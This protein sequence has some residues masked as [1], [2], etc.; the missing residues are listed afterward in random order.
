MSRTPSPPAS[1]PDAP[2][3]PVV[4]IL[5]FDADGDDRAIDIEEFQLDTLGER[6]LAWIDLRAGDE[7][8]LE[9]VMQRL[10]LQD[11]PMWALL[12]PGRPPLNTQ[13]DWFCARAMAPR[14]DEDSGAYHGDAWLLAVGP[15]TV[16]TAHRAPLTFLDELF[17]HE[18]PASQVGVMEADSFAASLLDRML[19]VYLDQLH[20]FEDRLD[21]LEVKILQP[22]IRESYLPQLRRMRRTVSTLR[23]LLASHRDLFD[24]LSRADFRPELDEPMRLQFRGIS[25]RYER[26]VDAVENARDLVIGSFELY[27]T[28]LSQRTNQSMHALTFFTV[29]LGSLAVIA[30]ALGMNFRAPLFESGATGFWTTVGAMAI[31]VAVALA[32]ARWRGWWR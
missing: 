22:K 11:V 12:E 5:L 31:A 18:D 15:Q 19:T 13:Q 9:P 3:A 8:A 10:G 4:R 28:R 6:E 20:A 21:A 14:R 26:V 16:V 23:R 27:A 2:D 7:A 25:T 17:E 1:G 29:L 30:G 32:V 24:A